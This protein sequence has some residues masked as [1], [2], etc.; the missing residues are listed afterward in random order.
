[1]SLPFNNDKDKLA[2]AIEELRQATEEVLN[3]NQLSH[4][5]QNK[6]KIEGPPPEPQLD[7][8]I[9]DLYDMGPTIQEDNAL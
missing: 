9:D 5:E 8:E 6:L 3:N 4:K 7:E 1:M 2:Q